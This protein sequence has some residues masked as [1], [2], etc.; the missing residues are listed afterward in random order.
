MRGAGRV[1]KRPPHVAVEPETIQLQYK[2]A[3]IVILERFQS[4]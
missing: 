4:T 2:R 3:L 1:P